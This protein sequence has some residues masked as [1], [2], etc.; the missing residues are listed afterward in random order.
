MRRD[1]GLED[2]LRELEEK[3]RVTAEKVAGLRKE[4]AQLEERVRNL[5]RQRTRAM[6]R[7]NVV[8]DK[9]ETLG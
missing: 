2:V 7:I 4:Q 9:I 8:L 1:A 6:Q 3:V 5:E